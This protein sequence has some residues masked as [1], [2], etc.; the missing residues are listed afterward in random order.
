MNRTEGGPSTGGGEGHNKLEGYALQKLAKDISLANY[1]PEE[2]RLS[3]AKSSQFLGGGGKPTFVGSM[4]T[5]EDALKC[6][7]ISWPS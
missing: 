7:S 6:S 5:G 3:F 1:Y 2:Y 4:V